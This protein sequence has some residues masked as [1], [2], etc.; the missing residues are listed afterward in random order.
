MIIDKALWKLPDF[1]GKQRIARVEAAPWV[2][3]YLKKILN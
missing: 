3:D 1:K 2:F